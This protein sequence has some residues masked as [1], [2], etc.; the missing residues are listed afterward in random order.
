M[1]KVTAIVPFTLMPIRVAAPLSSETASIAWPIFVLLIN[2]V[3][4]S[5]IITQVIIVTIVTPEMDSLPPASLSAGRVTTEVNC[6]ALEPN[7]NRATFCS[8]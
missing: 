2:V 4:A 6:L 7:I 5:M 8:R 1:A 3:R